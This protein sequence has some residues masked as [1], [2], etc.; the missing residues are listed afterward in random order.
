MRPNIYLTSNEE[1]ALR[2]LASNGDYSKLKNACE[3]PQYGIHLFLAQIRRKTGIR[4][5]KDTNECRAYLERYEATI[6][7]P[8]PTEEQLALL[9]HYAA[10]DSYTSIAFWMTKTRALE[11][12][13]AA[14]DI[15]K[16]VDA[17][18]EAIGIFTRD[19]QAR[20]VQIRAYT[21]CFLTPT[22]HRIT[23]LEE[24]IVREWINGKEPI[25][26][27]DELGERGDYVKYKLKRA[28]K[29]LGIA[30][31]GR[32]VQR[33]LARALFA[34][35]DAQPKAPADEPALAPDPMDDPAF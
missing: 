24:K 12:P 34:Q 4:D 11:T 33:S 22:A 15:P 6:A 2:S 35:L 16:M 25:Q 26:I 18:C 1:K 29:D 5:T 10:G 17:A 7:N 28:C 30:A 20:R 31:K 23:P 19:D 32:G 8:A 9:R 13:L 3:I 27:A 21:V 14:T